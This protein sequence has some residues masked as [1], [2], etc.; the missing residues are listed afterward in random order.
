MDPGRLHR[1]PGIQFPS[2]SGAPPHA[3]GG[4]SAWRCETLHPS[5]AS[6]V[7][8]RA[9]AAAEETTIAGFAAISSMSSSYHP[10]PEHAPHQRPATA[11]TAAEPLAPGPL[12]TRE[13]VM[14]Q[15]HAV[16]CPPAPGTA[17]REARMRP[18]Y[19]HLRGAMAGSDPAC[20]VALGIEPAH[21]IAART[22]FKGSLHAALSRDP[23]PARLSDFRRLAPNRIPHVWLIVPVT[24]RAAWL[25]FGRL[26]PSL[27]LSHPARASIA[28]TT[29][30]FGG[31]RT[32]TGGKRASPVAIFH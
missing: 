19:P 16:A 18:A 8:S 26:V 3:N 21:P 29:L 15:I 11:P 1:Q 2:G 17:H 13:L 27:R 10:P 31:P 7:A 22:E 4:E 28:P 5:T 30:M 32:V 20:V 14:G 12:D 6:F 25:I 9:N 23:G 24:I